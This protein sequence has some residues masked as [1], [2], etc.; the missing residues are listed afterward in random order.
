MKTIFDVFM[1]DVE[2]Q[3]VFRWNQNKTFDI[4]RFYLQVWADHK[5]THYR[6]TNNC[7]NGPCMLIKNSDLLEDII[8]EVRK[9]CDN[10]E[11]DVVA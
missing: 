11:E 1:A 9:Y 10:C 6:I 8:E 4:K 5:G 3:V 2:K 7:P